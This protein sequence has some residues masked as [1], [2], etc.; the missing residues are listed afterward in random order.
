LQQSIVDAAPKSLAAI[1]DDYGHAEVVFFLQFGVQIDVHLPA[2]QPKSG[3]GCQCLIA[4]M[5]TLPG[6]KNNVELCHDSRLQMQLVQVDTAIS[7]VVPVSFLQLRKLGQPW[8]TS[9]KAILDRIG[10]IG[11]ERFAVRKA[12]STGKQ[13]GKV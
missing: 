8:T 3:E 13:T 12:E 4:Q 6:I 9:S 11:G 7:V 5:A 1:D 10:Q 2:L